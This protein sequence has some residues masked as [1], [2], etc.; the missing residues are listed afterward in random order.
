MNT[1]Q[2]SLAFSL[3]VLIFIILIAIVSIIIAYKNTSAQIVL[4]VLGFSAA[5]ITASMQY[6]S[7]KDRETESRLFSEKQPVYS[8]LV[9]LILNISE[10]M[11]TDDGSAAD[12]LVK[13]FK[14]IRTELIIW[15]HHETILA[16]DDFAKLNPEGTPEEI[17]S[18][19]IK[20][21]ARLFS[22][23]RSDLGHKDPDTAG[24]DLA[25]GMLKPPDRERVAAIL[26]GDTILSPAS[27]DT[28]SP[29]IST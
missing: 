25:L 24:R 13:Q 22:A 9:K 20:K 2:K 4:G 27:D 15:G 29:G 17:V 11:Q 12:E 5:I 8:K 3:F 21:I 1:S 23:I 28:A 18:E 16:F 10:N 7:A 6:K 14:D 26:A 19:G